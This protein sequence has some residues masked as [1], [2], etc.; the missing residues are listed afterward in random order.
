MSRAGAPQGTQARASV[1]STTSSSSCGGWDAISTGR[2][3]GAGTSQQWEADPERGPETG[4]RES[5]TTQLTL[6]AVG[7]T[8]SPV[9]THLLHQPRSG[10][11]V[12]VASYL[13]GG[14]PNACQGAEALP[15]PLETHSSWCSAPSTWVVARWA[16][17]PHTHA[18]AFPITLDGSQDSFTVFNFVM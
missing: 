3:G 1:L 6:R 8:G 9:S 15:S 2:E 14:H 4:Q 12:P 5:M 17:S 16:R 11:Q 13:P 10:R 18:A 7:A